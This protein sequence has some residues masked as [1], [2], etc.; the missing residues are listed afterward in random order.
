MPYNKTS[1]KRK[2]EG[3]AFLHACLCQYLLTTCIVLLFIGKHFVVISIM[4]LIIFFSV[5]LAFVIGLIIYF[6]VKGR[7]KSAPPVP[8][9]S[10]FLPSE[11]LVSPPPPMNDQPADNSECLYQYTYAANKKV[12][13]CCTCENPLTAICCEVCGVSF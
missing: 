5:L 12:C 6:A 4:G 3:N 13:P 1:I 2:P 8:E 11:P 9:S 7:K 10:A